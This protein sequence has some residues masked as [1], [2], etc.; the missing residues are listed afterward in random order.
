MNAGC[1]ITRK[2]S[3]EKNFVKTAYSVIRKVLNALDSR[4]WENGESKFLEFSHY[5]AGA[6]RTHWIE[7]CTSYLW[8]ALWPNLHDFSV[9]SAVLYHFLEIYGVP[10]HPVHPPLRRPCLHPLQNDSKW[11][12]RT[13][14][15]LV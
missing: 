12:L 13:G 7:G 11:I 3:L 4:N 8:G 10:V 6:T 15:L 14:V 1:R 9:K 5:C 2:F